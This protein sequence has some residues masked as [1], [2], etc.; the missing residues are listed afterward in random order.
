MFHRPQMLNVINILS[1]RPSLTLVIN[2]RSLSALWCV[3]FYSSF[4]KLYFGH[5]VIDLFWIGHFSG[6]SFR[7]CI[8]MQINHLCFGPRCQYHA[9]L[10][11]NLING[12]FNNWLP[13]LWP[14]VIIV[15]ANLYNW[16]TR[17]KDWNKYHGIGYLSFRFL[18]PI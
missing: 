2:E 15:K 7:P 17:P 8:I 18:L 10:L 6:V 12:P 14:F 9:N 5:Y 4:T 11:T 3:A 16:K 1:T 13:I